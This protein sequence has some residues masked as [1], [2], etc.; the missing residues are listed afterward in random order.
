M[1]FP[2]SDVLY[3]FISILCLFFFFIFFGRGEE[4]VNLKDETPNWL[5]WYILAVLGYFF[6]SLVGVSKNW[7]SS[8]FLAIS[9]LIILFSFISFQVVLYPFFQVYSEPGY[10]SMVGLVPWAIIISAFCFFKIFKSRAKYRF[11]WIIP[12]FS[13]I[14]IY[15]VNNTAITMFSCIIALTIVGLLDTKFKCKRTKYLVTFCIIVFYVVSALT[16]F[17]CNPI[18]SF[19]NIKSIVISNQPRVTS[20]I[21]EQDGK[22]KII[23]GSSLFGISPVQF[24]FDCCK[25]I[26]PFPSAFVGFKTDSFKA[27]EITSLDPIKSEI[28]PIVITDTCVYFTSQIGVYEI[29]DD[30]KKSKDKTLSLTSIILNDFMRIY[31]QKDSASVKELKKH[32]SMLQDEYDKLTVDSTIFLNDNNKEKSLMEFSKVLSLGMLNALCCDLIFNNDINSAMN[33]FSFQFYQTFFNTK[34]YQGININFIIGI[35][36]IFYESS[37][38]DSYHISDKDLKRDDTFEA[39]AKMLSQN[40]AFAKLYI[41]EIQNTN[42]N[43]ANLLDWVK[44]NQVSK[45][46]IFNQKNIKVLKEI[47]ERYDATPL[48]K[49]YVTI[50]QK[51]LYQCVLRNHLPDYNSFFI[52]RFNEIMPLFA[53]DTESVST[54]ESMS[55]LYAKRFNQD[56]EGF[57]ELRHFWNM[58]NM[59]YVSAMVLQSSIDSRLRELGLSPSV[60]DFCKKETAKSVNSKK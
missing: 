43:S 19:L 22:Y 4:F 11:V 2:G 46:N 59:E 42:R 7:W 13:I 54:Y 36:E 45:Q 35:N 24:E 16:Y 58:L 52:N 31:A 57:I 3:F 39:W 41:F 49:R 15:L 28:F 60:I 9:T 56:I 21:T 12:I 32:Q 30:Y 51:F 18:L 5:G 50:V 27:N 37:H 48:L 25:S 10:Q 47:I 33:I 8:R 6:F 55:E 1:N 53:M 23:D 14:I 34:I 44:N 38:S 20:L 29:L 40:I 26:S 17:P